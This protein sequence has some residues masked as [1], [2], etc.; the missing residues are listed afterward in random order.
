MVVAPASITAPQISAKKSISERKASSHENSTSSV[1]S[2]A[3]CT[4]F[5]AASITCLG[6]I[7]NLCSIW[8]GLVAMKVWIRRFWAGAMASPALRISRSTARD[9]EHTVARVRVL[10]ISLTASKSPGL[11]AAK[12]ASITSTPNFSSWRATRTF[13]SLVMAAP[14][15]CSPS[16]KV[17][18]KIITRLLVFIA[19][20]SKRGCWC[21]KAFKSNGRFCASASAVNFCNWFNGNEP[22]VRH[23]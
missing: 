23:L 22:R 5:T 9:K 11:A 8:M 17:V 13:S 10:A 21:I 6:F 1:Y 16:R 2:L 7:F 12:P 3:I 19:V 15:D 18:S 4:A 20:F 14:G